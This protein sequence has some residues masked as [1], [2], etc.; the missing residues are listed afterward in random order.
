L[1]PVRSRNCIRGTGFPDARVPRPADIDAHVR[2]SAYK[3]VYAAL[4]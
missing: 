4:A 1:K 3:P 2:A